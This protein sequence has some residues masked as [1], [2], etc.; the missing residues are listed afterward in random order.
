MQTNSKAGD[1][2]Q[3]GLRQEAR[4]FRVWHDR[5]RFFGHIHIVCSEILQKPLLSPIR[6]SDPS[7]MAEFGASNQL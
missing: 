7:S 6:V 4:K 2:Q 3:V 5:F 1:C